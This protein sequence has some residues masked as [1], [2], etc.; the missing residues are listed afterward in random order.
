MRLGL[1][2]YEEPSRE[3]GGRVEE[4]EREMGGEGVETEEFDERLRSYLDEGCQ[5]FT[6][7]GWGFVVKKFYENDNCWV[8]VRLEYL[9]DESRSEELYRV[10]VDNLDAAAYCSIGKLRRDGLVDCTNLFV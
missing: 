10:D 4:G 5:V 6:D 2:E 7:R 1:P 3:K 8:A 9:E